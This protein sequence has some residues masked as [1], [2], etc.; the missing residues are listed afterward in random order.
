[1]AG[2]LYI[3]IMSGCCLLVTAIIVVLVLVL[4]VGDWWGKRKTGDRTPFLE[5]RRPT[6]EEQDGESDAGA[7]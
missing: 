6:E 4:Y 2:S 1:M 7:R 3:W 5:Y